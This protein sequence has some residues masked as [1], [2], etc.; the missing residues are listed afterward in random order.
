VEGIQGR[1][2]AVEH[3]ASSEYESL[4]TGKGSI[5]NPLR[6][7]TKGSLKFWELQASREVE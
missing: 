1:S 7:R 6:V 2:A 4:G 5:V 3:Y